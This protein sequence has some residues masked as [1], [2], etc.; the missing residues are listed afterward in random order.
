MLDRCFYLTH[1]S[2]IALNQ[3]KLKLNQTY[4]NQSL[5]SNPVFIR[6]FI[7]RVGRVGTA[8]HINY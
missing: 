4:Y 3:P 2:N 6:E 8:H 7:C 1:A 5:P